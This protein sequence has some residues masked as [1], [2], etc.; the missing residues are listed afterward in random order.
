MALSAAVIVAGILLALA[1]SS[2]AEAAFP[3]TA[4]AIAFSTTRDGNEDFGRQ[5]VYRM[6]SD[7]FGQT[8]LTDTAR[9][10]SSP[11]WSPDGKKVA[12]EAKDESG[13]GEVFAMDA[14]GSNEVN[15]TNNNEV[16]DVGPAWFPNGRKIAFAS[17]RRGGGYQG[18]GNNWEL[19]VM[20]LDASGDPVGPP[21][22]LTR[23]AAFDTS[24][25]VSPDG[26]KIAFSSDRD[27]DFDIYV[28]LTRP[29]GPN[30]RPVKLTDNATAHDE[31]PDWSPDGTKLAFAGN[32]TFALDILVMKPVPEGPTN[33]PKNLTSKSAAD[34]SSPAWS[35]DGRQIAFQSDRPV[36]NHEVWRMGAD[37]SNKVQLTNEEVGVRAGGPDWQPLP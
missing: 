35:P 25:A 3:G 14:D 37:G 27:G 17:H 28:M 12:F 26:R 15:L 36:N 5:N 29:E 34:D 19:W 9:F 33:R 7:G 32:G 4:G 22:R 20:T 18:G 13:Y 30:N 16:H 8:R 10:N 11:S 1:G 6:D 31:A 2:P 21:T 23:N 24:P